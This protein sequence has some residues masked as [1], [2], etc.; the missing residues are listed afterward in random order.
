MFSLLLELAG[1]NGRRLYLC[2]VKHPAL[3][4][5]ILQ[6][7]LLCI[8]LNMLIPYLMT[9][10]LLESL[11]STYCSTKTT[12]Y[13]RRYL[14]KLLLLQFLDNFNCSTAIH[15][16][17]RVIAIPRRGLNCDISEIDTC[18]SGLGYRGTMWSAHSFNN[19]KKVEWVA[20]SMSLD[21]QWKFGTWLNWTLGGWLVRMIMA[22]KDVKFNITPHI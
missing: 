7:I 5:L 21:Q 3:G 20:I 16:I 13:F 11:H 14:P 10:I 1:K 8:S 17:F 2:L 19:P 12:L 18:M 6:G 22:S 4:K 15:L 9:Y